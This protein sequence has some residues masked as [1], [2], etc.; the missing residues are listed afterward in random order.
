MEPAALI[1]V[2]K[3]VLAP[4]PKPM[5]VEVIKGKKKIL[6]APKVELDTT[7]IPVVQFELSI[8]PRVGGDNEK[9][10]VAMCLRMIF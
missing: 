6:V 5:L 3:H 1:T 2:P 8:K 9:V 7:P 4:T 10:G